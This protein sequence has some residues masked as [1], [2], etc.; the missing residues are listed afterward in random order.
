MPAGSHKVNAN[1]DT[2]P[3]GRTELPKNKKIKQ[4]N[5]KKKLKKRQIN[6][7]KKKKK[8][9]KEQNF[10]TQGALAVIVTVFVAINDHLL[11]MALE[12]RALE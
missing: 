12:E 9:K 3:T 1:R 7:K 8:K 5:K 11:I 2:F 10:H 4:T 6:K